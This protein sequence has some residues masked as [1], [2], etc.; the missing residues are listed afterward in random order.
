MAN[1]PGTGKAVGAGT[2][3]VTLAGGGLAMNRN[4]SE[5]TALRIVRLVMEGPGTDGGSAGQPG[6]GSGGSLLAPGLEATTTPSALGNPKVFMAAKRPGTD[7]ERIASLAFYL[8]YGRNTPHFKTKAL[9]DLNT[10]AAGTRFSN[11]AYSAKNAVT[12]G[13]LAAA[14][15]GNRQITPLGEDVVKA[16]PDREAVKTVIADAPGR[17]RKASPKRRIKKSR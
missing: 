11:A 3:K 12:T 7:V 1:K 10:E 2:Y 14:G 4:I 17:R 8:T 15:K 9:T 6:A 13:F 5:A 16:L